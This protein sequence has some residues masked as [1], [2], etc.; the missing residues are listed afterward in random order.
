MN[1]LCKI[2]RDIEIE[3]FNA[4]HYFEFGKNFSHPP[5]RHGFWEMVYVDSGEINAVTDG[6]GRTLS[7]GQLIFH[8]PGELHAHLSNKKVPNNMLVLSF[9]SKSP[10]MDF[11]D[12][13]IFTLDKTA[14]TLLT[15]FIREAREAL[16]ELPGV[17]EDESALDFSASAAGALQLLECYLTE[18]LLVLRRG[19]G[20]RA[21]QS[22]NSRELAQNSITTLILEYMKERIY[23]NLVIED[24]CRRFFIGKSKLCQLFAESVGKSPME[25]FNGLK[26]AEAKRLLLDGGSVS[27]VSD[28][29]SYSSIYSFSRAFKKSVGIAPT[30]YKKKI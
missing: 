20:S 5:E 4:I 21:K 27:R 17:Y 9:T 28:A 15:L 3:G 22:E 10:A 1:T 11:F 29:L 19:G 25:Y 6:I 24:V 8:R 30:E 18:L 2:E 26:I 13:K 12:K 16:G 23:D 14:K 7:Q